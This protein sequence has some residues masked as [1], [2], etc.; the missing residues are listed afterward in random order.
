M[1]RYFAWIKSMKI[2]LRS[3]LFNVFYSCIPIFVTF[4]KLLE[5]FIIDILNG[6]GP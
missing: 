6:G 3:F 4:S 5:L 1:K 2:F